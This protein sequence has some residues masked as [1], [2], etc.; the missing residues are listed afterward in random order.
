M[1]YLV[2]QI[3]FCLALVAMVGVLVGWLLRGVGTRQRERELESTWRMRLRQRDTMLSKMAN[4]LADREASGSA[5]VTRPSVAPGDDDELGVLRK[6]LRENLARVAQLQGRVSKRDAQI[7]QMFAEIRRIG[8][9]T[10]VDK[11]LGQVNRDSFLA[12]GMHRAAELAP[13]SPE[14]Q[15]QS[16]DPSE[17]THPEKAS[18]A[19][20]SASEEADELAFIYGVSPALEKKLLK[21]G[22]NSYRQIARFESADIE[23]VARAIGIE[24]QQIVDENWVDGARQEHLVKY[25]ELV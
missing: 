22:I 7:S 13:R 23:R 21:I 6:A 15:A 9:Q 18:L 25:G 17:K 20:A 11:L 2:T 24:P 19:K 3:F 12:S 8:G 10:A 4:E 16:E 14:A 1:A 5:P